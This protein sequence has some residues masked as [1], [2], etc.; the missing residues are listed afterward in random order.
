[1]NKFIVPL[2][3]AAVIV[4]ILFAGC[5]PG[6]PVTPPVEP[7]VTPPVEPPVTPP[8]PTGPT[9]MAGVPIPPET[10]PWVDPDHVWMNPYEGLAIKPDG[11][12]YHFG[13]ITVWMGDDWQVA[14]EGLY[15]SYVE[16]AGGEWTTL[17]PNLDTSVQ[18]SMFEDITAL[19]EWDAITTHPLDEDMVNSPIKTDPV[20]PA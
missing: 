11:T 9:D 16:R 8:P 15:R 13:T 14:K 5:V 20:G 7:P 6:A 19:G 17:D 10:V 3:T 18:F 1:M 2:V 4:S 12:P